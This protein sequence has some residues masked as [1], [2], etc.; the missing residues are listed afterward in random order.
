MSTYFNHDDR[1]PRQGFAK[2]FAQQAESRPQGQA[3]ADSG[4][5]DASRA[6]REANDVR[7]HA[8]PAG[9]SPE[10]EQ[11]LARAQA[12]A[13]R[14]R[15]N[16]VRD[17]TALCVGVV[18]LVQV[19]GTANVIGWMPGLLV[20]GG[21]DRLVVWGVQRGFTAAN[22]LHQAGQIVISAY[23]VILALACSHLAAEEP[24]V[25][26]APV[27]RSWLLRQRRVAYLA[28]LAVLLAGHAIGWW[29]ALT[30]H[31][32]LAIPF[33]LGGTVGMAV[34]LYLLLVPEARRAVVIVADLA[35]AGLNN[36]IQFTAR[37]RT[38]DRRWAPPIYHHHVVGVAMRSPLYARLLGSAHLEFI[39]VDN[40]NNRYT[41]VVK[42]MG[43]KAEVAVWAAY[44]N[45]PFRSTNARLF[46]LPPNYLAPGAAPPYQA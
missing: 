21:L 11:A 14:Q 6:G 9:G 43:S 34:L 4:A 30:V 31:W 8:Q 27:E 1:G 2:R 24:P 33:E 35:K 23:W 28:P 17:L 10:Q 37:V 16:R 3:A 29:V 36:H 12:L 32:L 26:Q 7:G 18:A 41:E 19:L 25:G 44:L 46:T 42:F 39:Y 38:F 13:L 5:A 40:R 15:R 45:G 22:W 20:H